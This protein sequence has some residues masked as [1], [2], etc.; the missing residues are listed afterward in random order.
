M[1]DESYTT[2]SESSPEEFHTTS[3]VPGP[4]DLAVPDP[5]QFSPTVPVTGPDFKEVLA[6]HGIELSA[7]KIRLMEQYCQ[8][9]WAWNEKINLTRH[10]DYEKFVCHDLIDSMRVANVL[11]KGERVLDVGTGGGVPGILIAIL[12]PDV[13]VELCDSTGKKAKAV[14]EIID[15]LGLNINVWCAKAEDLLRYHRFHTLVIRAVSKMKKLLE[16]FAPVWF[17]F[18][19][20][21]LVKGP[22]WVEERGEARH[23]HLLENV[24]LRKLDEYDTPGADHQS[25]L[26]SLCRKSRFEELA[27]REEERLA[28]LPCPP[29][30]ESV[31]V[32]NSVPHPSP[33]RPFH[34]GGKNNQQRPRRGKESDSS[35]FKGSGRTQQATAFSKKSP[36]KGRNS[37]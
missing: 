16:M 12:R 21:L 33:S 35:R 37:K 30:P 15:A 18:D 32:D 5:E 8:E 28:G 9:L 26:L 20:M 2:Q 6:A 36:K 27:K 7:K 14:G 25:Y 3:A 4:D 34:S 10:T 17:A 29:L 13:T 11:Q 19:R 31:G 1:S 24:A 23:F 22:H